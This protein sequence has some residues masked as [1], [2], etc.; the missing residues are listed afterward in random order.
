MQPGW[1]RTKDTDVVVAEGTL[2]GFN[3][4]EAPFDSYFAWVPHSYEQ[5]IEWSATPAGTTI[6]NTETESSINARL[7]YSKGCERLPCTT[8]RPYETEITWA[9]PTGRDTGFDGSCDFAEAFIIATYDAEAYFLV[10]RR[11]DISTVSWDIE[12]AATYP[13]TWWYSARCQPTK[14]S[15]FGSS[16]LACS[17]YNQS[18]LEQSLTY[19]FLSG[20]ITGTNIGETPRSEVDTRVSAK[21][22]HSKG[23]YE[24][25]AEWSDFSGFFPYGFLEV[26]SVEMHTWA[27]AS[28]G[29]TIIGAVKNEPFT[30]DGI[31]YPPDPHFHSLFIGAI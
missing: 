13:Y 16:M 29:G 7:G 6:N 20:W 30:T 8:D 17:S 2:Q 21:L 3:S 15:G 11:E 25:E 12:Y 22:I 18:P 23:Q 9:T 5:Y 31:T 27:R 10:R 14:E 26:T 24:I 1:Q 19:Y 4:D 28:A